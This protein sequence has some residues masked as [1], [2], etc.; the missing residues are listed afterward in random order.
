MLNNNMNYLQNNLNEFNSNTDYHIYKFDVNKYHNKNN[1]TYKFT[2][3][4]TI[5][6]REKENQSEKRHKNNS[7]DKNKNNC[8]PNQT[9]NLKNFIIKNSDNLELYNKLSVLLNKT[10]SFLNSNIINK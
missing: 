7:I 3:N 5:K 9:T 6:E 1:S 8:S 2:V 10:E 4:N